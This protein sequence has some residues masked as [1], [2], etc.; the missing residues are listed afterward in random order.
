MKFNPGIVARF[1]TTD[2][3]AAQ[4]YFEPGDIKMGCRGVLK[5]DTWWYKTNQQIDYYPDAFHV[6]YD[7]FPITLLGNLKG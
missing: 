3:F 6:S 5:V 4:T 1:P 2:L 7:G